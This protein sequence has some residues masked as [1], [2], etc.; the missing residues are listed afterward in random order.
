MLGSPKSQSAPYVC[1]KIIYRYPVSY[2]EAPRVNNADMPTE[3]FA[4]NIGSDTTH[5]LLRA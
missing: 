3:H 4:M 2:I 5:V 1:T